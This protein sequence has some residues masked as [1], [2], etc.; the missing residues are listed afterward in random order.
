MSKDE[1]QRRGVMRSSDEQFCLPRPLSVATPVERERHEY[2][3]PRH[4]CSRLL[5]FCLDSSPERPLS[6]GSVMD[7]VTRDMSAAVCSFSPSTALQS[8]PCQAGA[9]PIP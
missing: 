8:D 5:I 7:T 4:V 9:S 2:R 1:E 6:S 3:N